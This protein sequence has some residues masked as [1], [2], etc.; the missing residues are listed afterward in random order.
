MKAK[1]LTLAICLFLPLLSTAQK[2]PAGDWEA[3]LKIQGI[4][5]PLVVHLKQKGDAWEGSFDSPKQKAYNISLTSVSLRADTVE[6]TH[7]QAGI[8][9][10]G[11]FQADSIPG[12]FSQGGKTMPMTLRRQ[13]GAPTKVAETIR[14]Q[15]PKPPFN[16]SIREVK[17]KNKAANLT[18][19]GTLTVPA[20]KGPFPAVVL[21]SGSGP[22]DRNSE[23]F[24]HQ[25]F[26]VLAHHLTQAGIAVLRYDDRGVGKSTG[27]FNAATSEDFAGDALAAW[28]FVQKQKGIN[29]NKVGLIGHSEG[30]MVAP[31]AFARQSEPAFVV[32]MAGVGI[33][34][35]ALLAEQ[36]QAIGQS[37]GLS[38]AA[39][40]SQLSTNARTF[41]WLKTL[42]ATQAR[43]SLQAYLAAQ[44]ALLPA[45]DAAAR[46]QF[47]NQAAGALRTYLD[48]WFLYFIGYDPRPNLMKLSCPVL[49]INGDKDVQVLA[50]SNLQGIEAALK[51]GGNKN[52]KICS[53]PGLNHLF[54]PAKTGAVS[55]YATIDTTFDPA[56]ME[57]I[58]SW[59][60]GLN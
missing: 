45:N 28:A 41:H 49:A 47:E 7:K 56:A 46:E 5:L 16:Y 51:S 10:L 26:A 13:L 12:N 38:Q 19:A 52:Y 23:V 60:K 11:L 34:V 57:V 32:L 50:A 44:K 29:K 54:Q 33:P 37:E 40:D 8:R 6:F 18:L 24:D 31:I 59:I 53:L 39:I 22:Q 42:P 4:E 1:H 43:D 20:G 9:F 21:I 36:I 25:P 48:P 3:S 27:D 35:T 15:Q 55:E 2:S 14:P 58:A 17:I 30:G